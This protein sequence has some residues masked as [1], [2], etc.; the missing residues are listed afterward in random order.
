VRRA[1]GFENLHGDL[2]L[3]RRSRLRRWRL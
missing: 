3:G 1:H 2:G